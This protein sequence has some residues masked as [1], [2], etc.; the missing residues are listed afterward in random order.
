VVT[1]DNEIGCQTSQGDILMMFVSYIPS[2][3]FDR[4]LYPVYACKQNEENEMRNG[5]QYLLTLDA[6]QTIIPRD[7]DQATIFDWMGG[8]SFQVNLESREIIGI[9]ELGPV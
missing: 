7:G 8:P 4:F 2:K 9:K 5:K 6:P 1:N 3:S